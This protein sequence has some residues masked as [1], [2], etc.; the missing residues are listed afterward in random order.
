MA[1]RCTGHEQLLRYW[2]SAGSNR[3]LIAKVFAV[4]MLFVVFFAAFMG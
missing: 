4:I 2:K 1:I 3:A